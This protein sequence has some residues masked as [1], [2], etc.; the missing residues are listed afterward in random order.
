VLLSWNGDGYGICGGLMPE[1]AKFSLG[2]WDKSDVLGT[3]ARTIENVLQIENIS[4]LILYSCLARSYSL[5]TDILSE[6][7]KVNKTVNERVPFI[8]SY[9]GG[10][11]CPVRDAANA[12]SFH[13]NTVI[14]CAF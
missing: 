11:I 10:E 3:T 4:T 7:E 8:F 9:A 13:N 12:N 5:G 6:T 14:A 1:G 2:T